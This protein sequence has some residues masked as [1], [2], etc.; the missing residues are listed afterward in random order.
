MWRLSLLLVAVFLSPQSTGAQDPQPGGNAVRNG[1]FD[2]TYDAPN[3]WSG[4]NADGI[5]AAPTTY[6]FVLTD[7]GN[8]ARQQISPGVAVADLNGDGLSDILS[9]DGLGYVR[10]YFNRGSAQEP[11]F[12]V[13]ELSLPFLAL[14]EGEY[15]W[16][17]PEL[18]QEEDNE[19]GQWLNR[20]FQR[21]RAVRGSLADA[22]GDG[23]PDLIAGN[24]F[25]DIILV[26]NQGSATAPGFRQPQPFA[27]ALVATS[28]DPARRWGNVFAPLMFDW[29][30]NGLPDLLVGEG[31]YSANNIHLLLNQ[32]GAGRPSF[33]EDKHQALAL[34]QGR[35]QLSPAL[36][37]I[38]GDGQPDILV[39][40]RSARVAVHLN[41]GKWRFDAANPVVVPFA[42]FLAREGGLS[43]D[44]NQALT[45][46]EGITSLAAAD[47]TGDG[48]IDLVV[49]RGN[50]GHLAWSRNEGT[51]ESPK[52]TAVN[53]L[54]GEARDPKLFRLPS[55]WDA[56][57]GLGRGNFYAFANCVSTAEDPA[58]DPRAG[59]RV[60]KFGY[61][62]SPNQVIARPAANFPAVR[63]FDLT[64]KDYGDDAILRDSAESRARGG[65][66]NLFILRQ[67]SLNLQ[68]G[69]TYVLSFDVKGSRVANSRVVFGFRGLKRLG[70]DRI[71]RGAR[72]AVE[73]DRN[74]I[75][76]T[77]IESFNY[78]VGG[79][80]TTVT[81]E[82]RIAFPKNR[83]LN[84]EQA[85]S[86]ATIEISAE[87]APPDGVLYIDNV[88]FEPKPD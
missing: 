30:K 33:N 21:R 47:L 7:Q 82:F 5:L 37:D 78:T 70:E 45:M 27:S 25:G 61:L 71:T 87:L 69:K 28:K 4:V 79:G 77:V 29:D 44:V 51:K 39:A 85:T 40:D 80:W 42:G 32:G 54:R 43:S 24:Y 23:L 18:S 26:P 35:E 75:S 9:T 3:L 34:G 53:D 52:F 66:A 12:D 84:K 6:M 1:N 41:D 64:S 22:N 10:V 20:W 16:M 38:N 8:I 19:F 14:P 62:P 57:F 31:S 81:K 56:E 13:A 46:G 50:N 59:T 63:G 2:Q 55:Q 88:K 11:K 74:V 36:A 83:D 68:I 15:P 58:A 72:G 76:E 73:K 86:E 65:S 48:L 67:S 60:L 17:P 49:G